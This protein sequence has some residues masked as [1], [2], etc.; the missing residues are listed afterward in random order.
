MESEDAKFRE[1]LEANGYSGDFGESLVEEV[2]ST[3]FKV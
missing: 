1:Y 2:K 3:A